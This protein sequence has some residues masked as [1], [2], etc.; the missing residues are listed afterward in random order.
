MTTIYNI[1]GLLVWDGLLGIQGSNAQWLDTYASAALAPLAAMAQE[2]PLALVAPM[3]PVAPMHQWH[4]W[5]Q[6][7][8]WP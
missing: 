6:L 4:Q 7:H 3:A 8:Q 5:L 2:A 1:H